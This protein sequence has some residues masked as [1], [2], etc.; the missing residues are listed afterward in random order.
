MKSKE[1][2]SKDFIKLRIHIFLTLDLEKIDDVYHSCQRIENITKKSLTEQRKQIEANT[3]MDRCQKNELIDLLSDDAY[4]V[5]ETTE[6][7]GELVII[8]LYKT[9]E[10]AIN[11][12]LKV[13][14]LFKNDELKDIHKFDLLNKILINKKKIAIKKFNN[15]AAYDELRLINN[16]IKHSGRASRQLAKYKNFK[17]DEQLKNLYS[18]YK[19]LKNPANQFAIELRDSL[20][21]VI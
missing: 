4:C 19:R 20:L 15:F 21:K 10:I 9:F 6:L 17:F 11:N 1:M 3:S 14:N 13:S 12:A 7:A 2:R 18:H 5:E 8:A 16:S